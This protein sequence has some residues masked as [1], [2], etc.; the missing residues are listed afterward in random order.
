M[1]SDEQKKLFLEQL[2]KTPIIQV[3][4]EKTGISRASYYR[5]RGEEEF[6]K[7]ADEAIAEGEALINDM[8]E[9]QVISLIKDRNW[10]A[11]RFWLQHN[12]PK[13]ANRLEVSANINQP[14]EKMTPEQET[15]VR[16]A[17]F[18]AS[19]DLPEEKAI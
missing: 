7:A 5:L 2:K 9:V 13:Y 3:V 19:P 15:V 17:L 10:P 6:R 12:S 1:I 4:C 8:S 11:I 14:K 18:L 16:K